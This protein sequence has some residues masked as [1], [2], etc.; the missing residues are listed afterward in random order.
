MVL[1]VSLKGDI[2]TVSFQDV[3]SHFPPIAWWF[4]LDG[5]AQVTALGV[6]VAAISFWYAWWRQRKD[7]ESRWDKERHS[8]FT[9]LEFATDALYG[10]FEWDG[11]V[12]VSRNEENARDERYQFAYSAAKLIANE[13]TATAITNTHYALVHLWL[14]HRSGVSFRLLDR[15]A[16]DAIEHQFLCFRRELKLEPVPPTTY[17]EYALKW[18]LS[19]DAAEAQDPYYRQKGNPVS[20]ILRRTKTGFTWARSSIGNGRVS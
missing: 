13:E 14:R 19:L 17:A 6:A 16:L 3:T 1:S 8:V 15:V 10:I 4:G 7:Y 12:V 9:E 18:S 5:S 20:K 11:S 2:L